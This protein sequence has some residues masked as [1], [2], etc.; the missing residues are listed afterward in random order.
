MRKQPTLEGGCGGS[1]PIEDGTMWT[2]PV[3]R[4]CPRARILLR[5]LAPLA[6]LWGTTQA[7]AEPLPAPASAPVLDKPAS[8]TL[9]LMACRR[10]ALEN[11][12]ALRAA[13]AS[14]AAATDRA[15]ALD[16]LH[17]LLSREIPIRRQQASL[18]VTIAHAGVVNAEADA[19]YGVTYSYLAA[20]YAA[21]Q[22]K[23]ADEAEENLNAVLTKFKK[24][25]KSDVRK[26]IL[27][28]H[29]HAIAA[30]QELVRARRYEAIE[31]RERALA[32]LRE[33]LGVD[34]TFVI[35]LPRELPKI[36]A[37][38]QKDTILALAVARRGELVQAVTLAKVVAL[39]CDAQAATCLPTAR[40]FAS[41]SDIHVRPVPTGSYGLEYVPAAV[42]PEMPT[43][44][45]GSR[46]A[47]IQQAHDYADR[48]DAVAQKTRN[49]IVLEAENAYRL[50]REKSASATRL[51]K[52]HAEAE[53]YAG[54]LSPGSIGERFDPERE[55]YPSLDVVLQSGLSATRLHV[56][57]LRTWFESLAAL[58]MVERVTAGGICID[59]DSLQVNTPSPAAANGS[60]D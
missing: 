51:Q 52:A 11:Q 1:S 21:Q 38:L 24:A 55:R 9:T 20:V 23:V 8:S 50:W 2:T 7:G 59:F 53:K 16:R 60:G 35:D 15:A 3:L 45:A 32:A 6:F 37:S 31:G 29:E 26:D 4:R 27:A 14:L 43:Q 5:S 25:R 40:T 30:Y 42:A 33:A 57:S 13:Q 54:P 46:S 12:P 22:L 19:I 56:D 36:P 39:E 18:G 34:D 49:L 47:R 10:M 48:A 41:G 28:E 58:A 17:A 44:L